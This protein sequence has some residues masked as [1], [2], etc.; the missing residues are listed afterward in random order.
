MTGRVLQN[1]YD[2]G[3]NRETS[4]GS[5]Q[6]TGSNSAVSFAWDVWLQ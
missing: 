6:E 2:W 4:G 1:A 5:D 3:N